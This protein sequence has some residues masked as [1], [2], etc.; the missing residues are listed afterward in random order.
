ML[1]SNVFALI[2]DIQLSCISILLCA[3]PISVTIFLAALLSSPIFKTHMKHVL[4]LGRMAFY[5]LIT[6]ILKHMR[7][8][9]F[10]FFNLEKSSLG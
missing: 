8:R 1:Y 6:T 5:I 2:N 9:G 3:I 7:A 4:V 10:S